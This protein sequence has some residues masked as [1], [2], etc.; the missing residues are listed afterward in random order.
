M[1]QSAALTLVDLV[2]GLTLAQAIQLPLT[3]S[4]EGG[5]AASSPAQVSGRVVEDGTKAPI[6]NARVTLTRSGRAPVVT[7]TDYEG[8]YAFTA[9]EPGE[10]QLAVDKVGYV[11]PPPGRARPFRLAPG[12]TFEL[13]TVALQ[14]TGVITGR[15]VDPLGE[16]LQDVS[17][18][19]VARNS[20][21]AQGLEKP[22][23]ADLLRLNGRTNDLGEFRLYGLIPG[24]YVVIA[25][26]QPFGLPT[27][28][29]PMALMPET[30]YPGTA[31]VSAAQVIAV[32][33]GQ[34]VTIDFPIAAARTFSVSGAVV[35]DGGAPI[36]GATVR[37]AAD[38]QRAY[39]GDQQFE[40]FTRMQAA[41]MQGVDGHSVT[42]GTDASG[43]FTLANVTSGA[44]YAVAT[45]PSATAESDGIDR[46]AVRFVTS[47]PVQVIVNGADVGDLT[48]VVP[49]R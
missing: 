18:R 8:G 15:L 25:S 46:D 36:A 5:Q 23:V 40:M 45:V 30:Y 24:E 14:K 48:I 2:L 47:D 7:L 35:D 37:I 41:V 19:A 13:T 10:Y 44:Y 33:A 1:H 26:P 20:A 32:A 28:Q 21:A 16:P 27:G 38:S 3:R 9:L 12:Q 6:A 22:S 11:K 17:V 49:R 42:A 43:R 4:P 34:T 31:E 39:A 29:V